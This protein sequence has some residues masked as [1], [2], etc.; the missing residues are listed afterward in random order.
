MGFRFRL[1]WADDEVEKLNL[2]AEESEGKGVRESAGNSG[3]SSTGEGG[4]AGATSAADAATAN[5]DASA[6][7]AVATEAPVDKE[8]LQEF[9]IRNF[10]YEEP[11]RGSETAI[12]SAS[13]T[14]DLPAPAVMPASVIPAI[15]AAPAPTP[16]PEKPVEKVIAPSAE[17]KAKQE[18]LLAREAASELKA[19]AESIK[20]PDLPAPKF[21]LNDVIIGAESSVSAAAALEPD[22]ESGSTAAES[23]PAKREPNP[24]DSESLANAQAAAREE[25][26]AR[27]VEA[28]KSASA[29]Y[30]APF[31]L[32]TPLPKPSDW[33]FEEKL[34]NHKEWLDSQGVS[35]KRADLSCAKLEETEMIGVNL[36]YAD[37]H[38]ANLKS[39]DLLLTDLRDACLVRADLQEA[40]LVGANLEGANLEGASMESAMGLVPRQLAGATLRDADLPPQILQ[41]GAL[42]EFERV[43]RTA[44]HYFTATLVTSLL[45]WAVIWKTRD[46][47]LL[48]D[49][50]IIPYLHSPAAATAMPTDQIYLIAP[51]A[52]FLLY[53]V[54]QYQLQRL[55][56]A[57]LEL[58]AVFPDGRTLG[59]KSPR[60]ILG[61]LRA[62]FRWMNQDAPSTRVI[63][64]VIAVML[65]YWLAPATL[66]LYW[67]RYLTLQDFH[68]TVLQDLLATTAIG[69]GVYATAKVGRPQERW[70]L[71]GKGA[72]WVIGKLR[73]VSPVTVAILV[74]VLL[75]LL[76]AGTI[77]GIPHDRSR[78]PQFSMSNIRRWAPTVFWSVGY[79][80]YADLTEATISTKPVGWTG[81]D[82]QVSSVEG[83]YLNNR[84]IRYAQA[85]GVFLANA[86][87]W[88]A[89]FQGSFM[90]EA[91]LRNADLGQAS[92]RYVVLDHAQMSHAN[93]DRAVLDGA[94]L[95]RVDLRNANLSYS[96]LAGAVMVDAR[97]DGASLYSARLDSATM[98]RASLEKSDLRNA[99]LGGANLNHADVQQ[100]YFWSAQLPGAHLE[101]A[102]MEGAIFIEANLNGADLRGAELAGTV[103]NGAD[104]SRTNLDGADL[105]GSLGL[106][107][108][109]VCSAASRRGALLDEP[110]ELQVNAQCGPSH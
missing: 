68:G 19:D 104:M 29:K 77:K 33:A 10:L 75:T 95:A 7:Q 12:A 96:S 106:T 37:L 13:E 41:F 102:K 93:L 109:Q 27:E 34:A 72:G 60:I 67:A 55:W 25:I 4:G 5:G 39:A 62:H 98:I 36:R 58:P 14:R 82:D 17:E 32:D 8:A 79:H 89:D 59:E 97:L 70:I 48:T 26:V 103:L 38:A 61:L 69:V 105:R 81:A 16:A 66:I 28:G 108:N 2:K 110:L 86:H 63:E 54:F 74:C 88:Q 6:K 56:D 40:C 78:A 46:V 22:A 51:V 57:V 24:Q 64:K 94:N 49:S 76:A 84:H 35:G 87:L 42:A 107:A 45:S 15:E 92:L 47:Q 65:A 99:Y 1:P 90:S 71:Y 91:D 43:S 52:I 30:D 21:A 73:K 83:A 20:P 3:G 18:P 44:L 101:N 100:A 85:Y 50:A 23:G 80:P 9:L 11:A 31:S 53:L